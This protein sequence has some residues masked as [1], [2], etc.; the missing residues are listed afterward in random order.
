MA[1]TKGYKQLIEEAE[2]L[3]KT[4]TVEEVQRLVGHDNV[5]IVDIRDVRELQK[6]GKVPGAVHAPR[7]ML[8]FWV[9]PDS[10]YHRDLFAHE[11]TE[12]ILYCGSGWRSALAAKAMH[13]MGLTNFAHMGGGF[14]GWTEAN[15]DVEAKEA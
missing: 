8:E 1:V 13:E 6:L 10:P 2:A 15:G 12:Y 7:G 3:V 9:D 4:Y 5:T 11:D 14:S